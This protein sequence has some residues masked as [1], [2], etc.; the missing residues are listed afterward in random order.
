MGKCVRTE[1]QQSK[2]AV[3]VIT[4]TSSSLS[5]NM[6]LVFELRARYNNQM[7][8]E[9]T[10]GEGEGTKEP[11]GV[12]PTASSRPLETGDLTGE[13][14]AEPM[15]EDPIE[16]LTLRPTEKPTIDDIGEGTNVMGACEQQSN[17][18]GANRGR[19]G[20][21]KRA[22]GGRADARVGWRT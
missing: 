4:A 1:N 9:P 19:G 16:D 7:T 15:E 14:T 11:R 20:G 12:E 17:D 18:R 5:T 3:D 21:N 22:E 10:G 13:D 8:E 2:T 6:D